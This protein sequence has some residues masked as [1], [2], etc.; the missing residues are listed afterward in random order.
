MNDQCFF[1]KGR[2]FLMMKKAYRGMNE[3]RHMDKRL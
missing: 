2:L 1:D 3:L